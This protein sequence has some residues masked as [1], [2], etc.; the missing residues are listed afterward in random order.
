MTAEVKLRT[1]AKYDPALQAYFGTG[2]FRWFAIQIPQG[3][4][5]QTCA[6]IMRISTNSDYEMRGPNPLE[7][8][9]FQVDILD[10]DPEVARAAA[11]A[12]T[13]WFHRTNICVN[14]EFDSPATTPPNFPNFKLNE[15][16]TLDYQLKPVAFCVTQDWKVYNNTDN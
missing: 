4:F 5:P 16:E 1:I 15:R 8:I 2:P 13:D 10:Q 12:V 9:R 14:N 11:R 3:Y 7:W 6:R